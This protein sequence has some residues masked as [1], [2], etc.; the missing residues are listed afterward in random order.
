MDYCGGVSEV[1]DRQSS[2][3]GG[4][5]RGMCNEMSNGKCTMKSSRN[6]SLRHGSTALGSGH[7]ERA[8][9]SL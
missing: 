4:R 7:R 2:S 3:I 8:V 5:K 6:A 1:V 9:T